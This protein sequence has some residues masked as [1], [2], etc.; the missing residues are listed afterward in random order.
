MYVL[1]IHLIHHVK[2]ITIHTLERVKGLLWSDFRLG[3]TGGRHLFLQVAAESKNTGEKWTRFTKEKKDSHLP[4][5]ANW[6]F[7]HHSHA[8][9]IIL[10]VHREAHPSGLV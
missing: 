5:M 8:A 10:L 7:T 4:C 9:S 2:D 3:K 1:L 6:T